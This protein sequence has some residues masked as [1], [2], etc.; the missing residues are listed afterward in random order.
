MNFHEDIGVGLFSFDERLEQLSKLGDPLL[1]LSQ[2]IDF[3]FFRPTL[4]ESLY[5]DYDASVGGRPPFD[6]VLM[7]KILVLQRLYNLSD[8]AIEFQVKDRL[9]FMRFLGIDFAGRVPD[10]KTVWVFRDR[11]TQQLVKRLF[12]EM[13]TQLRDHNI[14]VG[15]GQIIDATFTEAPR[16][17][18]SK[19][20]NK[21][22]KAGNVP[23]EWKQQPHKL[24]QKDLD[25]RWAKKGDETHYGYKNHVICDRKSKLIQNYVV[26]DAAVH[27]SVVTGELLASGVADGQTV[28][29]DAAYRSAPIEEQLKEHG[30]KSRIHYK[31]HRNRPLTP[32]QKASNTARSRKRARVEHIFAFMTNSMNGLTVRGRSKA[33]NATVI[34]MINLTYNLCRVVQL[35][36]FL[37][38]SMA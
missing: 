23:E 28:Y 32:E 22:L 29:A 36:R 37:I 2:Q 26:T 35:N 3:E 25:A 20:E 21:S 38:T 34:G 16:Q 7:F 13:N 31:A 24:C 4:E 15:E 27:D 18:N 8:D 9:S 12:D 17:R 6:P 10:A 5:G 19:D 33:R 14:I 30:I 1:F 11:L